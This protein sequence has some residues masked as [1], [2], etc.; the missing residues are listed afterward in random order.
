MGKT[1]KILLTLLI[2][3]S[4]VFT[5]KATEEQNPLY[6]Y[7]KF[8]DGSYG[9]DA[10]QPINFYS[11]STEQIQIP[12][13]YKQPKEQFKATWVATIANLNMTTP[14]SEADFKAQYTTRLD[15]MKKWNMN[16]MIFQVRPLLDAFYPSVHNPTSEYLGGKQGVNVDYD[17]LEWMVD[18]THAQGLEYHAWFNPYRVTNIKITSPA[19]LTKLGLTAEQAANISVAD[20]IRL[21]NEHGLLADSNFAVLHPEN[22]LSFDDKLFLN[23]GLPETVTHVKSTIEEVVT[24]Y[25]VDGIHFDDYFYPYRI[26]DKY[27]GTKGE[28]RAAF[29]KY[30]I[31]NGY[32]DSALGLE[33]WR[34]DNVNKLV[35]GVKEVI[36]T[37]NTKTK[38]AV[39]Y[40]ISPFGIW[41]HAANDP[42]GSNT[43]T[44]S[45]QS[46]S[47][48]IYGDTYKWVKDGTLDYVTPQIY[49]SFG[50]AAAPYGELTKWWND[51]V[52]GTNVQLYIGHANYKYIGNG[53]WDSEWMNPDEINNQLHFNQKYKNVKGSVLFSYNDI[54]PS[55]LAKVPAGDIGKHTA[56][57]QSIEILKGD[58]FSQ[59]S[60]TPAKPWL[61]PA[62]VLAPTDITINGDAV[63]WKDEANVAPRYYVLY[64]GKNTTD[65]AEI[66]KSSENIKQKIDVKSSRTKQ[67][68]ISIANFD[69]GATYVLTTLDKAYVESAPVVVK[70]VEE[71]TKQPEETTK[72]PE[73][74][75]KQPEETTKQPEETTKQPEET[76]K[77]PEET[78]KQPEETTKQPEETTKQ[79][80]DLKISAS[81]VD[82]TYAP[83]TVV[84]EE[85]FLSDIEVKTQLPSD[86]TSDF[87]EVVNFNKEGKYKV[88]V[89]A[90]P[91]TRLLSVTTLAEVN[92][93]EINVTIATPNSTAVIPGG[94]VLPT[95]GQRGSQLIIGGLGIVIASIMLTFRKKENN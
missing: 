7:V 78:T 14:T 70:N 1:T 93:L 76:T 73:E 31:E 83:G 74:T 30:G 5:V 65:P 25:D 22:V 4:L 3:L 32:E 48:S 36:T 39:Q 67:Y 55:D 8:E 77:Q 10:Q 28:D 42:R 52:E 2:S 24:N 85:Q 92:T 12:K 84:T 53:G 6:K 81:K 16:A 89:K 80:E 68:N 63:A 82:I 41:E 37:H 27:F 44:G 54:I 46:Y 15:E 88:T 40:G 56:K 95:T 50:Q 90:A 51:T 45:S 19:M 21:F 91:G 62:A 66:I 58:T 47:R 61:S 13:E 43:P 94:E 35:E 71:T 20:H 49:W 9:Y 26:G 23:P 33:S 59:K 75:T 69:S 57:N 11:Q 17:A 60:L 87:K 18:T 34:R 86:I 72:Q 29:V 64:E 79:P 38:S